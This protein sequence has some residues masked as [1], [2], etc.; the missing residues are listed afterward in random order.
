MHSMPKELPPSGALLG[1]FKNVG[2][3]PVMVTLLE[4]Q[5]CPGD[6]V[7]G[8]RDTSYVRVDARCT[9]HG[10]KARDWFAHGSS[11]CNCCGSNPDLA[12]ALDRAEKE[13]NAWARAHALDCPAMPRPDRQK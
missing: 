5:T 11:S 9:G 7:Y 3:A 8:G 13:G 6:E 1:H 4:C 2:G 12:D 10:C